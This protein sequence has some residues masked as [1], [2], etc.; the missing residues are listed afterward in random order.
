MLGNCARRCSVLCMETELEQRMTA[1]TPAGRLFNG[2]NG[3]LSEP[4]GI[5]PSFSRRTRR[6]VAQ[7]RKGSSVRRQA[8][9]HHSF[10]AII[11]PPAR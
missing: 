10:A 7:R 1:M 5:G 8:Q 3:N 9:R 4:N 11:R 6:D 2:A